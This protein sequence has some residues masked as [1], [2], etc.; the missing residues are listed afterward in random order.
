[1]DNNPSTALQKVY[2]ELKAGNPLIIL[3]ILLVLVLCGGLWVWQ[4][5][6][7]PVVDT[8]IPRFS[9]PS[10]VAPFVPLI[11]RTP[12][13][14][15]THSVT[16]TPTPTRSLTDLGNGLDAVVSRGPDGAGF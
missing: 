2:E 4:T 12:N 6:H 1:M 9:H 11:A 15:A 16:A 5:T 14:V 3:A 7:N 8:P 13:A 10:A